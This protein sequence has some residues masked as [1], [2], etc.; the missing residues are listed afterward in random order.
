MID[1]WFA[2]PVYYTYLDK[3]I[4]KSEEYIK[5]ANSV[6]TK[7]PE[8]E[9][10]W[11]CTTYATL[12]VTDLKKEELFK[13]LIQACKE[14]ISLFASEL[15]IVSDGIECIDAWVN[16][17][18]YKDFQ[19]SHIHPNSHFSAVYYIKTPPNCGRIVFKAPD[20]MY[21]VAVHT[22]NM[23]SAKTCHYEPEENKLL[24]FRANTPHMVEANLSD[25]SRMS[26]VMNFRLTGP[27]YE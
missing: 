13:P 23:I 4:F 6:K 21:P 3:N 26:V 12:Y 18:E 22:H 1:L 7:T 17:A 10:N 27:N 19:E 15:S 2:T 11:R 24:I 5:Y 20:D 9:S 25:E 16:V 14:H 8:V